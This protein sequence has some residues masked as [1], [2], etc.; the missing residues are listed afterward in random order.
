MCTIEM[1]D[2][3]LVF[4]YILYVLEDGHFIFLYSIVFKHKN[5]LNEPENSSIEV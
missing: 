3:R 4:Y 2:G 1:E 5:S